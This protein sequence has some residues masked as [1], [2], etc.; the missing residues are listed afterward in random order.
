MTRPTG[1]S[2]FS[3]LFSSSSPF[4]IFVSAYSKGI[5][6]RLPFLFNCTFLPKGKD[7]FK[8]GLKRFSLSN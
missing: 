8:S 2:T 1:S 3:F 7:V 6:L 4:T 5:L